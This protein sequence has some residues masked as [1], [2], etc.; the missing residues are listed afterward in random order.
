MADQH[1]IACIS[2]NG[3]EEKKGMYVCLPYQ[4]VDV[5]VYIGI[6]LTLASFQPMVAVLGE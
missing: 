4:R 6:S 1:R 3:I 2:K 5:Y